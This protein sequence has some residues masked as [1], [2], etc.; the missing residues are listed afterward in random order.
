MQNY[1]ILRIYT[2]IREILH[3]FFLDNYIFFLILCNVLQ[4]LS[5]I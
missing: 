4:F 2:N 1:G 3:L 5:Y